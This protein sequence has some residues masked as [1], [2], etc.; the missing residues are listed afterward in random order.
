MYHR[1]HSHD[2][3][4]TIRFTPRHPVGEGDVVSALAPAN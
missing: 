4:T 1:L 2:G 3:H